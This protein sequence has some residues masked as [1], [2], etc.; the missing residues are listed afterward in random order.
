M[1]SPHLICEME[2]RPGEHLSHYDQ[3]IYVSHHGHERGYFLFRHIQVLV[4]D[5]ETTETYY[6]WAI[7]WITILRMIL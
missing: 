6:K 4:N 3:I 5:L 2:I 7:K 1:N